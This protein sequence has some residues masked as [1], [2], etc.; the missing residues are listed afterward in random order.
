MSPPL[1]LIATPGGNPGNYA[2]AQLALARQLLQVLED[3]YAALQAGDAVLLNTCASDKG[4]LLVALDPHA[5]TRL[6][7]GAWQQLDPLLRVAR[8]RNLRNG[9]F[10]AAQQAYVRARWAGLTA[11]AGHGSFYGA[12]GITHLPPKPRSALGHA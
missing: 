8:E 3:E 10:I 2:G 5:R 1:Q 11:A 4:R 6:G 12:D 7:A 9:D